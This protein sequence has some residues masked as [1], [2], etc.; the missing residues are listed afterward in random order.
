MLGTGALAGL[1]TGPPAAAGTGKGVGGGRIEGGKQA[2]S[3]V[4]AAAR[5]IPGCA[6]CALLPELGWVQ[7]RA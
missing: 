5:L 4:A 6:Q 2:R 3:E 1:Q 7:P